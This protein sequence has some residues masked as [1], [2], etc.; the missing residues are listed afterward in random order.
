MRC[1]IAWRQG[2]LA[3]AP[4]VPDC[5]AAAAARHQLTLREAELHVLSDR[6][7]ELTIGRLSRLLAQF[8]T[9]SAVGACASFV[10]DI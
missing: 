8:R 2:E 4:S 6:T 7:R 1:G 10:N 5:T 9:H 3:N